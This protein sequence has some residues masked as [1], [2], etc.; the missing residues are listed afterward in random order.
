MEREIEYFTKVAW[1]IILLTV[2][3]L[4]LLLAVMV[5]LLWMVNKIGLEKHMDVHDMVSES[6]IKMTKAPCF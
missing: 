2:I 6:Q 3:A 4:L 1:W 5:L